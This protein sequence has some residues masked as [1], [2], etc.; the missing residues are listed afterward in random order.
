[1][2][3]ET[4]MLEQGIFSA[5]SA[6]AELAPGRFS[7]EIEPEWTIGAK[8]NGGY[9]LSMLARAGTSTSVHDHVVAANA[10]YLHS[11]DP[12]PVLIE[13]RLRTGTAGCPRGASRATR[14]ARD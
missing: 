8:P 2:T 11:P 6:G 5:V 3:A 13:I 12:G 14:A 7:A 9:L 1:M 10:H 4:P